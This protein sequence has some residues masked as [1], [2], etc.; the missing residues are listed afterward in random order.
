[1]DTASDGDHYTIS[2]VPVGVDGRPRGPSHD[3]GIT[4]HLNSAF[5]MLRLADVY[6]AFATTTDYDTHPLSERAYAIVFRPDGTLLGAPTLLDIGHH[7]ALTAVSPAAEHGFVLY[8]GSTPDLPARALT[9]A[10]AADGTLTQ[11]VGRRSR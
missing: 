1:M 2:T 9:V 4:A 7:D 8:E 3:V 10:V 5:N 11:T 6:V